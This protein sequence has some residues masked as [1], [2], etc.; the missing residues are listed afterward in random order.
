M[1]FLC[2]QRRQCLWDPQSPR[3]DV[4]AAGGVQKS[5]LGYREEFECP[6]LSGKKLLGW[7]RSFLVPSSGPGDAME[8][9]VV[10][11]RMEARPSKLQMIGVLMW[12]SG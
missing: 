12:L 6:V 2:K 5:G 7:G 9:R 3:G 11:R 8:L 10:G 4:Q 1:C